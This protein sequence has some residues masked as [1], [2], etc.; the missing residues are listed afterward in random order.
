MPT[1]THLLAQQ[2]SAEVLPRSEEVKQRTF[3]G[4]DAE[5]D[6]Q[7]A[8]LA[9]AAP[10]VALAAHAQ[11]ATVV[12]AGGDAQVDLRQPPRDLVSHTSYEFRG[13]TGGVC[14]EGGTR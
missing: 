8:M 14:G 10:G 6:V 13:G 2:C 9:A 12:D 11:P 7:V 5:E 4:L 1:H 3:V